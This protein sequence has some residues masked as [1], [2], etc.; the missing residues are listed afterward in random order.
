MRVTLLG[1]AAG[2]GFPQWNCACRMCAAC[3]GRAAGVRPRTQDCIA[4]SPT[5]RG[6][7][8]VNASPDI[9]AQIVAS[10]DFTP[11]PGP[12]DTPLRGVLLTDAELDHALG[13]VMLREGGGLR[14]WAP[15]AVAHALEHDFGVRGVVARYRQWDWE[16][17]EPG[18]E[19]EITEP[20]G[21][22]LLVTA[23]PVS[24]KRPR[25]AAD[26]AAEGH[27]VCAYRISDPATGGT[28]LY[29]PCLASWPEGFDELVAG[30]DCLILDGTFHSAGEMPGATGSAVGGGEQKSMGHI[31]ISGPGGSLELLRAHPRVRR[32]YTHLNNTNPVLDKGS[33]EHAELA[34]AGVEVPRDGTTFE[35]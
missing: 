30:V 29:A 10:P 12:R 26:S 11:G 33:P 31:P 35:L 18:A 15:P 32:I 19:F 14:V 25:Y 13:L 3:R 16:I 23:I 2:G 21:E 1:T 20:G 8:L 24:G 22:R 34:A 4:V 6:W 5:G 17:A 28:L 9:R 7:F 27:W